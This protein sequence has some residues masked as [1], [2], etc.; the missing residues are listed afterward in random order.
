MFT[1]YILSHYLVNLHIYHYTFIILK[2][3]HIILNFYTR[4]LS[5]RDSI[6]RIIMH[7]KLSLNSKFKLYILRLK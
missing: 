2:T 4:D 1:N 5:N 3:S 7:L 6:L